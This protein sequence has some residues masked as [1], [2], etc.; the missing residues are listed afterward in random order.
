MAKATP[1]GGGGS[2]PDVAK[3]WLLGQGTAI[4]L[5]RPDDM[6]RPSCLD[7]VTTT[8]AA[9]QAAAQAYSDGCVVLKMQE[10]EI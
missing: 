7:M 4:A 1:A 6:A 10:G 3:G 9:K 2:G 8:Y 5:G